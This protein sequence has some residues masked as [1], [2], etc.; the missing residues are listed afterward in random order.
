MSR[1]LW[2]YA[3]WVVSQR[4][5]ALLIVHDA[6]AW[7]EARKGALVTSLNYGWLV[8]GAVSL[9]RVDEARRHAARLFIRARQHD[10]IGEAMGCRALARAAAAANNDVG[11]EHYLGLAQRSAQL[12]HSPHEQAKTQLCRAGIEIERGHPREARAPLDA[13]CEAFAQMRMS[14]HLQ[15]AQA[16]RLRL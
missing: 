11:V 8:D 7:I 9:G 2:G 5:E 13:A 10:R 1:A 6:T 3:N 4:P 12:R 16:L 15:Q 14:W